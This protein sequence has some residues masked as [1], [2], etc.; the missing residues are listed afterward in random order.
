MPNAR[1]VIFPNDLH[2]I[3]NE[4]DRQDVYHEIVT[5]VEAVTLVG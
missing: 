1:A 2:N 5:F 4:I 3:L